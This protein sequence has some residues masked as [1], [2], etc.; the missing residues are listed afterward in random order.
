MYCQLVA[1]RPERE[2]YRDYYRDRREFLV[3]FVRYVLG[4]SVDDDVQRVIA[5][6]SAEVRRQDF[7]FLISKVGRF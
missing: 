2:R 1:P 6:A 5:A 7:N 3:E 4:M